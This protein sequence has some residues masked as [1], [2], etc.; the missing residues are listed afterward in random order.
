MGA[1]SHYLQSLPKNGFGIPNSEYTEHYVG[2]VGES[3]NCTEVM[4]QK[5]IDMHTFGGF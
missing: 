5:K 3:S 1:E 4:N 2:G